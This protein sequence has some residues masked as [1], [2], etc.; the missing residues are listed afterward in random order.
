MRVAGVLFKYRAAA[1]HVGGLMRAAGVLFK[2]R[3]AATHVGGLMRAAGGHRVRRLSYSRLASLRSSHA[4]RLYSC[5]G[6]RRRNAGW[7]VGINTA[8]P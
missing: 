5:P 7:K 1:T 6:L 3:A 8:E 2:Y 4:M